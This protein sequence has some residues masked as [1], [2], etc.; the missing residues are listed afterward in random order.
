[1][2]LIYEYIWYVLGGTLLFGFILAWILRGLKKSPTEQRA[3]VDRDIALLELQQTK[4]ELD[5]LFAAQRKRKAEETL[6]GGPVADPKLKEEIARLQAELDKVQ[7]DA[8]SPSAK[9][10]PTHQAEIGSGRLDPS[11]QRRSTEDAALRNALIA[12]N[13]YLETRIHDVEL[14]LHE[15]AKSTKAV[16]NPSTRQSWL[17]NQQ[18][19]RIEALQARLADAQAK[20][21]SSIKEA[22]PIA[23][24]AVP[25]EKTRADEDLAR[26]RWRNRYLESRLAYLAE[27]IDP[28]DEAVANGPAVKAKAPAAEPQKLTKSVQHVSG[29]AVGAASAAPPN[30]LPRAPAREGPDRLAARGPRFTSP[31]MSKPLGEGDV[32]SAATASASGS[33][34]RSG[35]APTQTVQSARPPALEGALGQADDLT[36]ISGLSSSLELKLNEVGI[37]H[38]SQIANW[39]PAHETWIDEHLG[40]EGMAHREGWVSQAR[41]LG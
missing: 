17:L 7:G 30:P 34:Q 8:G 2:A 16:K 18:K 6:A 10:E 25:D 31:A 15:M 23:D 13:E 24:A 41:Q 22:S 3:V 38:F 5:S 40:L 21:H 37:W 1:M 32:T 28:L 35:P 12:R 20:P 11:A 33:L 19:T 14:R 36:R 4:D 9:P 39:S 29:P 27:T 26:L